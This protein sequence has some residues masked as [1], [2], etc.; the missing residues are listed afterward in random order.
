MKEEAALALLLALSGASRVGM[1][2]FWK[3]ANAIFG[4]L[5]NYCDFL[6]VFTE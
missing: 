5:H 2:D 1:A 3:N 4:K 6:G